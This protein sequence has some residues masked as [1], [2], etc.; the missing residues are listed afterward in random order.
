MRVTRDSLAGLWPCSRASSKSATSLASRTTT[1]MS[2]CAASAGMHQTSLT[3]N[4]EGGERNVRDWARPYCVCTV[5]T[6]VAFGHAMCN[7]LIA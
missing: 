4:K 7:V 6:V 3:P 1:R 2:Y 5:C